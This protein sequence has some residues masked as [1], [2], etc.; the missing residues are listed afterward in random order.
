MHRT[1]TAF[2]ALIGLTLAGLAG[3]AMAQNEDKMIKINVTIGIETLTATLDDTAAGR[4]F[5][6][7]L[8]LDITLDDYHG[9]E[10]V[11]DLGRQIDN[12]GA[13]RAYEPKAGDITQYRPWSNLAIFLKCQP[14]IRQ[15]QTVSLHGGYD[16]R[17]ILVVVALLSSWPF[18]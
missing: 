13:P 16:P 15:L 8:P 9:I 2:S 10:K 11:G 14:C 7:M 6:S 12:A 18:V 3:P 17:S 5:A 4:D 1:G